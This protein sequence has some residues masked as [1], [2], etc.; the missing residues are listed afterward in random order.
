VAG[1][2]DIQTTMR[3][4]HLFRGATEA[5]I[6]TLNRPEPPQVVGERRENET[7]CNTSS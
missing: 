2:K 3:Y 4:V 1:H 5:A 7:D 6:A